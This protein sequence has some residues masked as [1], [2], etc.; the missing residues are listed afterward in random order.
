MKRRDFLKGVAAFFAVSATLVSADHEVTKP[1]LVWFRGV[2]NPET[3]WTHWIN[4]DY[5][6]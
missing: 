3:G 6:P 5:R 4:M 2:V 1:A